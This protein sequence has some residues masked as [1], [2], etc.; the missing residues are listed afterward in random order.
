MV[1]SKK[2]TKRQRELMRQYD[3]NP[4]LLSQAEIMRKLGLKDRHDFYRMFTRCRITDRI[5]E[6]REQ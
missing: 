2:P 3:Q 4:F 5:E 6:L 1:T